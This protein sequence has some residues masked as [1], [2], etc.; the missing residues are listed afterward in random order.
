MATIA[1]NY[2]E[3]RRWLRLAESVL[4][5]INAR[6]SLVGAWIL[7]EQASID[8]DEGDFASSERHS[9]AAIALKTK[10]LGPEHPDVAGS[11]SN[12]AGTLEELGRWDEALAL[13][14]QALAIDEKSA[15]LRSL[16]YAVDLMTAGEVT[17]HLGQF[18]EAETAFKH[19]LEVAADAGGSETFMFAVA[20]TD[21]GD[22]LTSRGRARDA[23]A[24][25]ERA[26]ALENK[27]GDRNR[28]RTAVTRAALARAL[29]ESGQEVAA[30]FQLLPAACDA[31]EQSR[32]FRRQR[33]LLAWFNALPRRAKRPAATSCADL[34]GRAAVRSAAPP[35]RKLEQDDVGG[36]PVAE[37]P[38]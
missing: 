1:T 10:V 15:D 27:V 3:A 34:R 6:E 36:R 38:R 25:L 5:R 35:V 20:L 23:V 2:D 30:G 13:S 9:R 24:V 33:E 14:R 32:Y 8:F 7:N 26:Q 19:T 37:V 22:L 12:L 28:I 21:M 18:N 17:A 16:T 4:D 29:V 31:F 11:M